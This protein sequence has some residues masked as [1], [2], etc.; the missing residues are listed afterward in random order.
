MKPA[1]SLTIATT[2]TQA[3]YALPAAIKHFTARYPKVKLILRQGNP[4]PDSRTG[5]LGSCRYRHRDRGYR[6]F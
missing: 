3:R 2:H 4:Y 1:G 6:T 5:H